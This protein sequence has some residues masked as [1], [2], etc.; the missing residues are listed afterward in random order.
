MESQQI[1]DKNSNFEHIPKELKQ[2]VEDPAKNA[3][4]T[5]SYAWVL[6]LTF[7]IFINFETKMILRLF[8]RKRCV[9]KSLE[10]ADKATDTARDVKTRLGGA[11]QE[12]VS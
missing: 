2:S 9:S 10:L 8:D 11:I 7:Y 3:V 1:S 5:L 4:K 6:N 12:L